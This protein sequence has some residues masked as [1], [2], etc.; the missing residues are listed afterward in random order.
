M[1][2]IEQLFVRVKHNEEL[3]FVAIPMSDLKPMSFAHRGN[4]NSCAKIKIAHYPA[5]IRSAI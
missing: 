1:N 5:I 2:S 4:K 3:K